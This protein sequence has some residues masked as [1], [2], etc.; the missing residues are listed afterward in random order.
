M[1]GTSAHVKHI[2]WII[3]SFSICQTI[4][5]RFFLFSFLSLPANFCV[6]H[7]CDVVRRYSLYWKSVAWQKFKDNFNKRRWKRILETSSRMRRT[8]NCSVRC[9]WMFDEQKGTR[10]KKGALK[11]EWKFRLREA[12]KKRKLHSQ[13]AH[14]NAHVSSVQFH[15]A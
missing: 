4:P 12:I 6:C 13:D 9:F 1:D 11:K 10:E 3:F 14:L 5:K 2:K 7:V 15:K 8:E